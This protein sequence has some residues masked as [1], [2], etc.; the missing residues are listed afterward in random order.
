MSSCIPV[1]ESSRVFLISILN[2]PKN[3]SFQYD[4]SEHFNIISIR[5]MVTNY[6]FKRN[7]FFLKK[8][9]KMMTN[10]VFHFQLTSTFNGIFFSGQ[11]FSQ[12]AQGI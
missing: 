12:G 5:D 6:N 1:Q 9:N 4:Q 8:Q 7:F 10:I 3:M 2:Y 11:H